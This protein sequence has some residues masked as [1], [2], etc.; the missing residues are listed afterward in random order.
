MP[1]FANR[2]PL[3]GFKNGKLAGRTFGNPWGSFSSNLSF[4]SCPQGFMGNLVPFTYHQ[5]PIPNLSANYQKRHFSSS[6]NLRVVLVTKGE[7]CR[8]RTVHYYLPGM[9][10][11]IG[12]LTFSYRNRTDYNSLSSLCSYNLHSHYASF[13]NPRPGDFLL[14]SKVFS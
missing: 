8:E 6:D 9:Y 1:L 13:P 7:G 11:P 2:I 4:L 10:T 12:G 3:V 5:Y 14:L